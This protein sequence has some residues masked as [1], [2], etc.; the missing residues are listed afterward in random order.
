METRHIILILIGALA[1]GKLM[2]RYILMFMEYMFNQKSKWFD[3]KVEKPRLLFHIIA[4]IWFV[5][6]FITIRYAKVESSNWMTALSFTP[7]ILF[8]ILTILT[9]SASWTRKFAYRFIP[10]VES[11]INEQYS[12]TLKKDID[13]QFIFNKYLST[14]YISEES[15]EDFKKLINGLKVSNPIVWQCR[16]TRSKQVTFPPLFDLL[17]EIIEGGFMSV[18]KKRSLYINYILENFEFGETFNTPNLGDRYG[19]WIRKL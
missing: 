2:V 9:I 1:F 13:K 17:H 3:K 5:V 12:F 18:D 4:L 19:D 6:A 10:A 15:F 7:A 8:V 14:E 16:A 11:K